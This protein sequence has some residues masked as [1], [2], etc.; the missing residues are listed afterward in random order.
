MSAAKGLLLVLSGPS[1]VGKGAVRARLLQRCPGF[2]YGV[3][4]TTRPR[5]EGEVEG[6]SYFF[7]SPEGFRRCIDEGGFVEWAEVH[8]NLYGTPRQPMEDWLAAGIDVIVEKDIQGAVALKRAYPDAVYVFLLPPSMGAL[9][10]R[11][12][13]RGTETPEVAAQRLAAAV[14]ELSQVCSY[15]YAVMNDA[16]DEAARKL[17]AILTAERCRVS[18]QPELGSL[19]SALAPVPSAEPRRSSLR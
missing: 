1:G 14:F 6:V 12:A 19:G 11:I 4:A 8:G 2:R 3:S 9:E 15:D 17:E 7:L 16:L 5:R 18:R 10:E 13:Q